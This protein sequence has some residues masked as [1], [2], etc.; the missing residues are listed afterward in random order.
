MGVVKGFNPSFSPEAA[1]T[2]DNHPRG[3]EAD[4][5]RFLAGFG[6][7][8]LEFAIG[9]GRIALPLAESGVAV[10]GIELTA[11]RVER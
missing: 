5:V 4:T 1:S 3:D 10:D 11:G 9:T 7:S 8:A 2:Y 6:K